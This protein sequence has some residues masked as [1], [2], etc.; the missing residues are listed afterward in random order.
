M[1]NNHLKLAQE[2]ITKAQNDLRT[3]EILYEE[4]G[5]P[6]TL[7]FHC[8]QSVEKYLKAYLVF[9]NIH[10]EKIHYSWNLAK[11]CAKENKEFLN[12]E[13]ELKT[14]DAYYIESRY[15]PETRTYSRQECKKVLDLA[16]K[17]TQ[18]IV[19]EIR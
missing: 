16:E 1:K 17:L 6:D 8:H 18:F 11:L 12:F 7:C 10:F 9:R 19:N 4:K 13:E 3:A 5:P 15:P 2:W 14:L